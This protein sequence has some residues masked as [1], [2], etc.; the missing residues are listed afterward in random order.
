MH[1][2]DCMHVQFAIIHNTA[3]LKKIPAPC[4]CEYVLVL[5]CAP[6]SAKTVDFVRLQRKCAGLLAARYLKCE[7]VDQC[8]SWPN[9]IHCL[10]TLQQK[11]P[12]NLISALKPHQYELS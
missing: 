7:Q 8:S 10:V 6:A 1:A 2:L 12:L 3:M 4:I 5:L 11:V 9:P